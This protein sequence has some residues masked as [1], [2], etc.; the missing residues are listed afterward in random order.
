MQTNCVYAADEVNRHRLSSSN[1][2]SDEVGERLHRLESLVSSLVK[3]PPL[4]TGHGNEPA[5]RVED[6]LSNHY[7][8][9]ESAMATGAP[10]GAMVTAQEGCHYIGESHWEAVLQDVGS[11][12][13]YCF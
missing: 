3:S 1:R 2:G 5:L 11:Q 10:Y 7:P 6:G 9:I 8:S 13:K 4:P 12:V